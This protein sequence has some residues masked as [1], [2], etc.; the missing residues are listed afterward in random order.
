MYLVHV[1]FQFLLGEWKFLVAH[2]FSFSSIKIGITISKSYGSDSQRVYSYNFFF[3]HAAVHSQNFLSRFSSYLLLVFSLATG[4]HLG[5]VVQLQLWHWALIFSLSKH[6]CWNL[7]LN[8]CP[9]ANHHHE[10]KASQDIHLPFPSASVSLNFAFSCAIAIANW[11]GLILG[12]AV[13]YSLL[14][15]HSNTLISFIIF[16]R[17]SVSFLF[18]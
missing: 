8:L 10:Q 13:L 5:H 14:G 18:I 15:F 7:L 11:S 16:L 9:H 12:A 4:S 6:I 2:N 3:N 1:F 17:Y